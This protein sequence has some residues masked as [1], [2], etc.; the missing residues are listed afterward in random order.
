MEVGAAGRARVGRQ[1]CTIWPTDLLETD[2]V[3]GLVF[4][5]STGPQATRPQLISF[6]GPDSIIH[7]HNHHLVHDWLR[8]NGRYFGPDTSVGQAGGEGDPNRPVQIAQYR[9]HRLLVFAPILTGSS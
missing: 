1:G 5:E 2:L 7:P 6:A 8:D 4:M 3:R 9:W